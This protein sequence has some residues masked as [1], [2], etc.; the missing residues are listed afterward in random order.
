MIEDK[1]K[2][3][4][5]THIPIRIWRAYLIL[6][7]K[8]A[9]LRTE[10]DIWEK[11]YPK[12]R[13]VVDIG[14]TRESVEFFKKHG[15]KTIYTIGD[16]YGNHVSNGCIKIDIEGSE[17]GMIIETHYANPKLVLL[18]EYENGVKLWRLD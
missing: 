8:D 4:V 16:F 6:R 2:R 1:L 10:L 12:G 17:R 5:I 15:A 18:H 13:Q 9:Y 3:F 11:F 14:A 7:N